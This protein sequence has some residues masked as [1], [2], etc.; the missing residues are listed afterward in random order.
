MPSSKQYPQKTASHLGWEN[1]EGL[2]EETWESLMQKCAFFLENT[3][4]TILFACAMVGASV[5]FPIRCSRDF[6]DGHMCFLM[7]LGI[8]S[9]T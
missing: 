9:M 5:K 3:E 7:C 1:T 4:H 6:H 8:A 2:A